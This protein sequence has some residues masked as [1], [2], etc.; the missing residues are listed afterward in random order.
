MRKT[1]DI[2]L[3]RASSCRERS[4]PTSQSGKTDPAVLEQAGLTQR[5]WQSGLTVPRSS[6]PQSSG[7]GRPSLETGIHL[8]EVLGTL[9]EWIRGAGALPDS[10][11]RW[12]YGKAS[13]LSPAQLL[14]VDRMT[15][16]L[17]KLQM[18]RRAVTNEPALLQ[19]GGI[20]RRIAFPATPPHEVHRPAAKSWPLA[21]QDKTGS[22]SPVLCP[23]EIISPEVY[24]IGQLLFT[25]ASL[26]R[27]PKHRIP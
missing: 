4:R 18:K 7:G 19:Y 3:R 10:T 2:I 27:M 22:H 23:P 5:N 9:T 26:H 12:R 25:N 24:P 16:D 21:C 8:C 15:S 6:S 11:W 17:I 13:G 20:D 1:D 14:L